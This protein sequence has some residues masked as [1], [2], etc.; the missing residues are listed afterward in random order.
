MA[1]GSRLTVCL[2]GISDAAAQPTGD[3]AV[4]ADRPAVAA[5]RAVAAD[6]AAVAAD[7]DSH[8]TQ[9]ARRVFGGTHDQVGPAREF[10]RE[11]LGPHHP[12]ADE[13]VLLV[14]ELCT[15]AILHTASGHG[16]TFE[17]AITAGP[18]RVRV[19]V[20]D[21][22]SE[23]EPVMSQADPVAC[24]GRGLQLV[25]ALAECWGFGGGPDRRVVFFQLRW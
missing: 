15:N 24:T 2:S 22:G 6:G 19:E 25:A 7:G 8:D 1:G 12:A 14:S 4:A 5:D 18:G 13:V 23:Q 3:A 20:R 21:D 11:A 17:V 10:T 16:G 9:P